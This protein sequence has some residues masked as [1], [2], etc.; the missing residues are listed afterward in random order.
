MRIAFVG[1]GAMGLPMAG[2]LA[3]EGGAELALYDVA[4]DRLALAGGLGRPAVSVADA[5][6]DADAV[7]SVL[8]ADRHVEAVAGEVAD[9]AHDGLLYVDFSTIAPA[10]IERVAA[11]LERAGVRTV[12]VAVTRGT[13]AARTGEL[14]LFVGG[15]LPPQLEPALAALASEVRRVGGLGAAKAVKIGNNVI[16]ACIDVAACEAIVLGRK[17][18][19]EPGRV[20][21]AVEAAAGTSWPLRNHVARHVLTGD[22]GPGGFSTVN[23]AKDVGLFVGLAAA[24]GLAAPLAG[25][26]AASYRGTI[27]AGFGSDYHPVV[28]R[29]LEQCAGAGDD[30]VATGEAG[31]LAVIA[32]AV[33]AVQLLTTLESLRALQSVGIAPAEAAGHL[34]SGSASNPALEPA[35]AHLE[36][37]AGIPRAA[38]LAADLAAATALADRARVP[39]AL[40]EAARHVATG[41][42]A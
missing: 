7:F 42:D 32:R 20:V 9:A 26:A 38:A 19:L 25:A 13:A 28:I 35:R 31:D 4:P 8:P 18:G 6:R 37:R 10:T 15:E 16:V 14:A 23:M 5:A 41:L 27:A 24:S 3:S 39:A 40:L 36:G 29:W 22:L 21:E 2:R 12:S 33:G 17:L 1:L 30:A 34:A 11:R